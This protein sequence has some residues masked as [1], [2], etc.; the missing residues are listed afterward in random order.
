M[1]WE[2]VM[3][4]QPEPATRPLIEYYFSFISL[5]SYV[6]SLAFFDLVRRYDAEVIFKPFDLLAVFA[7]SG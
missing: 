2:D 6:G 7:A 3:G 4:S 1:I 5:W